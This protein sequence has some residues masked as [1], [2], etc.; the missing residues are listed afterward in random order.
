MGQLHLGMA[1]AAGVMSFVSPCCLPL[2]PSFLS[3]ITGL[4]LQ[5]LRHQ[6]G[7][8]VIR[9]RIML[10]TLLF[11]CGFSIVFYSLGYGA[12]MMGE[13]FHSYR[14][15]IRQIA[16]GVM[17]V[18]G[19]ILAG[20]LE[21]KLLMREWKPGWQR[22]TTGLAGSFLLGVGYAAG[23]S[24]CVG[25]ILAGV[26]AL[27]ASEPTS[28]FKLMTAYTLGFAAPFFFFAFYVGSIQWLS[29]YT[30]WLTRIGGYMMVAMG[31]LL[32]SGK[33]TLITIWLQRITPDWLIF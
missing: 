17:I 19:L 32:L 24:P 33:L 9:L 31:V 8:H 16:G 3:Y 30:W 25:P 4:S 2:Y 18:M 20:L 13:W 15:E 11:I 7:Q 28:W 6:G 21:F 23:W 12:G 29:K 27:A 22:F 10:H 5:S 14:N 1:F 26:I